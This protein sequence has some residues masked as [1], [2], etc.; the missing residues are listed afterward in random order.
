MTQ[1]LESPINRDFKLNITDMLRAIM[2]KKS[3]Q[4]QKSNVSRE[5]G[6]LG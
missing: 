1:I 4:I 5:R 3:M 6:I 2:E